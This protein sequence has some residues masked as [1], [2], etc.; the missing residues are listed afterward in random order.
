MHKA[1]NH[2]NVSKSNEI[3][4]EPTNLVA[5][6]LTE[7]SMALCYFPIRFSVTLLFSSTKIKY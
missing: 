2:S 3:Y 4:V 5:T 1:M 6:N 7:N